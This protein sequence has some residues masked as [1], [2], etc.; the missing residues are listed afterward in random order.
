MSPSPA[1]RAPNEIAAAS[2]ALGLLSGAICL[3]RYADEPF[4]RFHAWQSIL[5]SGFVIL[6]YIALDYV[7]LLGLGLVFFLIAG[8]LVLSVWLMWRAYRGEWAMLPLLGD[9]AIERAEIE[10][11][12]R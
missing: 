1:R 9:V 2:Y 12:R 5:F 10:S 3:W 6:A 7:P 4:V 8:A 11:E